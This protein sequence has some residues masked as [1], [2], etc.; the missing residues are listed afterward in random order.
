MTAMLYPFR[1]ILIIGLGLI[2]LPALPLIVSDYNHG[3]CYRARTGM[4]MMASIFSFGSFLG[5][6]IVLGKG[7]HQPRAVILQ[8]AKLCK[9][10]QP[11]DRQLQV[12]AVL[13]LLGIVGF[14]TWGR[15]Q[16]ELSLA[17]KQRSV[18]VATQTIAREEH[19]YGTMARA[20]V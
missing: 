6:S 14:G 9:G 19:S 18:S 11:Y 3:Q 1:W 4:I 16:A 20:E 15:K 12:I 7:S 2:S 8:Y 5:T 10:E 17:R 13:N